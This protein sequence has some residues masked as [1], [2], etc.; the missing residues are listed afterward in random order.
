MVIS[1]EQAK[2]FLL[3]YQGLLDRV[4]G[5][6]SIVKFIQKV[7]CIQFDPLNVVG[8]NP[9]LV[10]QARIKDYQP[11]MLEDLLYGDRTLVDG[12]DKM[13]AIYHKDDWPKMSRVR[14]A[15]V[16]EN[17]SV[18]KNRGTLG[19]L[20][21]LDQVKAIVREGPKYSREISLGGVA[22]G[23]W[24]SSK[25]AN[26][27]LDHL[28]HM[29]EL[30]IAQKTGSQ[31][32]YDLTENLFDFGHES[33][34]TD[35]DFYKWYFLRRI[36]SLGLL[37]AKSGGAWLGHFVSD[38]KHRL[39]ILEDLLKEGLISQV[40]IQDIKEPFYIATSNIQALKKTYKY[41]KQ[42]RILGPLDNICWDRGLLKVL[43][44]FDYS[45]EVYIPKSKRQY[46]YYV[47]PV[48][49][50]NQFIGRFEPLKDKNAFKINKWWSERPLDENIKEDLLNA[51]DEFSKYLNKTNR[52]D[53]ECL[54]QDKCQA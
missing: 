36:N 42:V 37:W 53:K 52:V 32:Q 17:L 49:Y 22:K 3:D 43:F 35:K 7:S 12:W 30:C 46:G 54:D 4:E 15:H 34:E 27:A 9:D 24:S 19:A 2:N 51:F 29:G 47:L 44:D 14:K 40:T 28:F 13:M 11:A 25:Y 31:K 6:E 38:K 18:M 21:Y 45:W 33:F 8:R 50:G 20:D 26:V 1:K 16:K 48:L 5:T 39:E 23:R 41:K 10:L